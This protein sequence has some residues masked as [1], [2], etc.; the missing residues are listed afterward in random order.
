MAKGYVVLHNAV[1]AWGQGQI[2]TEKETGKID[3]QRLLDLGAVREA[4]ADELKASQG[5]D[6]SAL[7]APDVTTGAQ[8]VPAAPVE[9]GKK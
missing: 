4:T 9:E 8:D 6:D 7:R 5:G 1:G 2:V 3:M